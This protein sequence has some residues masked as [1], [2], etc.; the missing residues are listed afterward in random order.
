M[1]EIEL[2]KNNFEDEVLKSDRP[3]LIDFWAD[4]CAPCRMLSPIIAEIADK[5]Q[6]SVKVAKVN[7]TKEPELAQVFQVSGIPLVVVIKDGKLVA[8]SVGYKPKFE[9]EE[10]LKNTLN[11]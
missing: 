8:S 5:Y 7:V 4:G 11:L 2:N 6:D 10:L 9:I 3:V 1:S